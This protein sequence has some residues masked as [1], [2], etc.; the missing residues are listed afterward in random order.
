MLVE[1][2]ETQTPMNDFLIEHFRCSDRFVQFR[3][4]APV[5][6]MC[7]YFQF[8]RTA[9]CYGSYSGRQPAKASTE[10][11]HD[12]L[13]E[14]VVKDGNV[15]LPFDPAEVDNN[16]R[17]ERYTA[18]WI[19]GNFRSLLAKAYYFVRPVLSVGVRRHLQRLHLRGWDKLP[20]LHWPVDCSAD[21]LLGQL[22]LLALRSNRMERMPFIWF[23]PEGASSAAIM[24]DDVVSKA[25]VV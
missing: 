12:A 1:G 21:D 14:T 4:K 25:A 5:S 19:N 8:G 22:L 11:F 10:I 18:D 20:F 3:R 13:P 15:Y 9:T 24:T 23:W 7:G 2:G 17:C 16:L 6:S